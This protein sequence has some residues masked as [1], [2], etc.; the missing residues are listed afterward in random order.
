MFN[1]SKEIKESI[2]IMIKRQQTI[3]FLK[4]LLKKSQ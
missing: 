3:K 2:K 1:M 4:T